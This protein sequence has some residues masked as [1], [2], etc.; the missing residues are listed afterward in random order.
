M[1][2]EFE[3]FSHLSFFF[4]FGLD[5]PYLVRAISLCTVPPSRFFITCILELFWQLSI[6]RKP[7]V[8][9]LDVQSDK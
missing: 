5:C 8:C 9:V 2:C 4:F 6:E 3:F 7:I 1:L